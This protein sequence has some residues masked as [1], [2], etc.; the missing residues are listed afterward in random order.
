MQ[1]NII[2]NKIT[3]CCGLPFSVM[4]WWVTN[5]TLNTE[6]D[7]QYIISKLSQN[8]TLRVDAWKVLINSGTLEADASLTKAEFLAWFDCERQPSCEQLK[9]IV[10]GFRISNYTPEGGI[11]Y[12][13]NNI[14]QFDPNQI[15]PSEAL[16]N[17]PTETLAGDIIKRVDIN[18]GAN[19][20]Y[21]EVTT[22]H[23]GTPMTD[24]KSD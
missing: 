15:V 11:N 1:K 16:Y 9:L 21:R 4:Y 14:Y 18:T 24:I 3:P 13:T 6:S 7:R 2:T 23:D 17:D 20:N 22:W 10:E 5:L 8:G 19:V 12:I